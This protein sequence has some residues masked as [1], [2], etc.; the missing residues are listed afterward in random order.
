MQNNSYLCSVTGNCGRHI[1]EAFSAVPLIESGQFTEYWDRQETLFHSI[2]YIQMYIYYQGVSRFLYSYLGN[3][4]LSGEHST[5]WLALF[6]MSDL[7]Q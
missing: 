2:D 4:V 7:K 5:N 1:E 6:C 3:P